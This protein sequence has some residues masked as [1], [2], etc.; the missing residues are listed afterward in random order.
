MRELASGNR[1]LI[2]N[3]SDTVHSSPSGMSV[4]L[5]AVAL[6]T[7]LGGELKVCGLSPRVADEVV[8]RTLDRIASA[9]QSE[10]EAL[11]ACGVDREGS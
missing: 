5:R 2:L 4:I 10:E 3:L 11:T 1:K 6:A 9:H 8:R 7:E